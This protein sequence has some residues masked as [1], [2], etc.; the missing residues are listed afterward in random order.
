ML[1]IYVSE[2][3]ANHASL[4]VDEE[5]PAERCEPNL[6]GLLHGK[7]SQQSCRTNRVL[8]RLWTLLSEQEFAGSR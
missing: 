6:S 8:D 2:L 1:E 3:A 4:H 7:P 5:F